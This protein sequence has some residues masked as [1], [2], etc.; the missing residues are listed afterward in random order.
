M[1]VHVRKRTRST[2]LWCVSCMIHG[3]TTLRTH[4]YIVSYSSIHYDPVERVRVR[5][6]FFSDFVNTLIFVFNTLITIQFACFMHNKKH[7]SLLKLTC[8]IAR[9]VYNLSG[10][11]TKNLNIFWGW[12]IIFAMKSNTK[13][14]KSIPLRQIETKQYNTSLTLLHWFYGIC[15][16]TRSLGI[17]L[18]C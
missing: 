8:I 15:T 3:K 4:V 18:N 2:T 13:Q 12:S 17:W 6:Q 16:I 9:L 11:F 10:N 7:K 1:Y 14:T 5:H